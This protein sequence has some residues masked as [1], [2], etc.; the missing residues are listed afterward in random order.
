MK[1]KKDA[2]VSLD[3]LV[4]LAGV[5]KSLMSKQGRIPSFNIGHKDTK[6]IIE[7]LNH[8]PNEKTE[9]KMLLVGS[10]SIR[11]SV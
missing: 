4:E 5:L 7:N 11:N 3:D 8:T 9:L 2:L 1:S 6:L 10:R